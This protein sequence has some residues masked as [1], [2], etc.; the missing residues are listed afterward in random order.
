MPS[1]LLL[2]LATCSAVLL[3]GGVASLRAPWTLDRAVVSLRVPAPLDAPWARRT[4]PWV[5]VALGLWLLLA[6]GVV[7][8]LVAFAVVVLF[9]GYLALIWRAARDGRPAECG[10][11]GT[12]GQRRVTRATV[13]RSGLLLLAALLT[14][15]AALLD[16]AFLPAAVDGTVL[17]WLAVTG[18][19]AAVAALVVWR[20]PGV[21]AEAPLGETVDADGGYRRRPVPQDTQLLTA[22][23]DLVALTQEAALEA[24]LLVFLSPGCGSCLRL[25]PDLARWAAQ[26]PH[27]RA[28][29]VLV[30]DRDAADEQPVPLVAAWFD[31]FGVAW[32]RLAPGSPSAVLV[33]TDGLLAGGPVRGEDGVRAFVEE[34]RAELAAALPEDAGPATSDDVSGR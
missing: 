25:A 22:A 15:V 34:V 29:P 16:I 14:L 13:L 24:R 3:L 4:L 32:R 9:A 6:T 5:E 26:L 12:L 33:G 30:A 17:P 31:P 19:T 27:V 10:C 8:V 7:L 2:P 21:E 18:L 1:P 23:G 11:F 20:S 28:H